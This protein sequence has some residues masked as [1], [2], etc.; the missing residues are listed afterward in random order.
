MTGSHDNVS[1][2]TSRYRMFSSWSLIELSNV[3]RVDNVLIAALLTL[4]LLQEPIIQI[5]AYCARFKF[6]TYVVGSTQPY[7]LY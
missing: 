2:C 4:T 1:R 6:G 3:V 5:V 7:R